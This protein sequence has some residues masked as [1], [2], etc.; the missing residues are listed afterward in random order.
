[1]LD[2]YVGEHL[3]PGVMLCG[4]GH[5][6]GD[7]IQNDNPYNSNENSRLIKNKIL[8]ITSSV[9]KSQIIVEILKR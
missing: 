4:C 1:M 5:V 3:G 6:E 7:L 2:G 9:G 8:G